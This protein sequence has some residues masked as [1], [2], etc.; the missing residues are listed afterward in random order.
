LAAVN[1]L[2]WAPIACGALA[3]IFSFF[4]FYSYSPKSDL[5][6]EC[7]LEGGGDLCDG[8]S[9]SAWH[10]FVPILG[11][12]LVLVGAG[13]Y[14]FAVFGRSGNLKVKP[15][16]MAVAAFALGV[17]FLLISIATTPDFEY[18]GQTIK[19]DSPGLDSGV[20]WSFYIVLLLA[21]AGAATAALRTQ[22]TKEW[23]AFG[24][25]RGSGGGAPAGYYPPP[26]YGAPQQQPAPSYGA[27]GG[28]SAPQQPP[29]AATPAQGQQTQ[30]NPI[31][32]GQQQP[33]QPA[34][35]APQPPPGNPQEP[36]ATQIVS[37][38]IVEQF[39]KQQGQPP[40]GGSAG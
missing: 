17:L 28:Y 10:G 40:Q 29:A 34:P 15:R 7:R 23:P 33:S 4:G 1:P 11:I 5:V 16:A 8:V 22:Q 27:P 30:P 20:G 19:A 32:G 9:T 31:Y 38:E 24:H 35:S 3:L 39:R 18:M 36:A 21:I 13:L 2:D 6:S 14:A 12:L 37:P 25:A 26:G